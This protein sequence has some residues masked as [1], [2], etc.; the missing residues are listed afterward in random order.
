VA[1]ISLQPGRAVAWPL[2]RNYVEILMEQLVNQI[3][4]RTGISADKART[5]VDTVVGYLKE[6]LPEP[7]ASKLDG[8][9]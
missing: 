8:K 7:I 1:R 3:T 4:Q 6:R 5:A 2:W 9:K